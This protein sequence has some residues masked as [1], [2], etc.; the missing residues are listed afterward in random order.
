MVSE[1]RKKLSLRHAAKAVHRSRG[2]IR[3]LIDERKVRV[4][5][6]GGTDKRPW[7]AVY[8]DELIAAI[9]KDSVWVPPPAETRRKHSSSSDLH[10]LVSSW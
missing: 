10:P 9:E 7:L 6:I 8:L 2:Y 5:K 4:F 3:S 1:M